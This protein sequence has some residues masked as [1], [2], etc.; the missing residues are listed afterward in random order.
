MEND[1][2]KTEKVF[3]VIDSFDF[4]KIE[5]NPE[6]KAYQYSRNKSKFFGDPDSKRNLFMDRYQ[7]ILHRVQRNF[8]SLPVEGER[9]KL[10]TI[11]YLLTLSHKRLTRTFIF[12]CLMQGSETT[13]YLEDPTGYIRL[14]FSEVE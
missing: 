8:S 5:Y 7:S 12:G 10:Q 2:E 9:P 1:L 11:D 4:P 3:H 13:W 6:K 14:D